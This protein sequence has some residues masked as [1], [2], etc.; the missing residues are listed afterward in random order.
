M[1]KPTTSTE[2]YVRIVGDAGR[3]YYLPANPSDGDIIRLTFDN[4]GRANN[5]VDA[6]TN[7]LDAMGWSPVNKEWQ[8]T[9]GAFHAREQVY[10][11]KMHTFV[12]NAASQCWASD[13]LYNT[14]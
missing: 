3:Y 7:Y 8:P 14:D 4:D 11:G 10:P 12:F 2:T 5:T 6:G 1:A 9:S 13:L